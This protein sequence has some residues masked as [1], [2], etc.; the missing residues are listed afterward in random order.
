[1]ENTEDDDLVLADRKGNTDDLGKLHGLAVQM[2][3]WRVS[4][5]LRDKLPTDAATLG[6]ITKFL[7]DNSITADAADNKKLD[8][9]KAKLAEA[10]KA[11]V[12]QLSDL[13]PTGT[14]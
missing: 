14:D 5:D 13:A 10:R 9:L 1:M 4:A 12:V 2:M 7:K 11:K 8:A 3:V 6:V